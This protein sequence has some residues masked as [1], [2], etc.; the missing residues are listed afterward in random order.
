M[1][2]HYVDLIID[3][4]PYIACKKNALG[5]KLIERIGLMGNIGDLIEYIQPWNS[6][7]EN[8]FFPI[9]LQKLS[10]QLYETTHNHLYDEN[11][12]HTLEF[13]ITTIKNPKKFNLI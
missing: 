1:S 7:N 11:R 5:K 8:Y 13:E 6:D 9:S 10:I 2:I 12:D 3:E 4:I